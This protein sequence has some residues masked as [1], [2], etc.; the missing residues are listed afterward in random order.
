MPRNPTRP[1][2]G[3]TVR[4]EWVVVW[5]PPDTPVRRK[6]Y[7]GGSNAEGRARRFAT[8]EDVA[9]WHPLLEHRVVTT[10][11]VTEIVSL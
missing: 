2:D 9:G 6:A 7:T 3:T 5:F 11:V 10:D 1:E 4:E 8:R